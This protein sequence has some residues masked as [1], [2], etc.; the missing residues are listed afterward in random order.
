MSVIRI[1]KSWTTNI[2][3]VALALLGPATAWAQEATIVSPRRLATV[4]GNSAIEVDPG[5]PDGD[6]VKIVVVVDGVEIGVLDA[7]PW[8][9]D[10]RAGDGS[11]GHQISARVETRS[12][13]TLL[14]RT[15]TSALRI[16]ATEGVN[17]VNLYA[18]VRTRGGGYASRLSKQDFVVLEDGKRQTIERFSS[19]RKPLRV[20][21]VL[22][23]SKTMDGRKLERAKEAAREF[24]K[25][26]GPQD[27]GMVVT[28]DNDVRID[29]GLTHDTRA[30]EQAIM[31]AE[32]G[33]GTALYDA[34]YR[35]ARKLRGFD[36]RRVMVLLS[37]G[38]DEAVNGI[39]PGSLHTLDE[40]L[41]QALRAEV[42]IF[43]IG[44][45]R[46]LGE[47]WDFY[48]TRSLKSILQQLANDTGG[49]ALISSGPGE[50]RRAFKSVYEDLSNQYTLA[51]TPTNAEGNG[52]WRDVQVKL[53]DDD[54]EVI[55]RKGY[56]APTT[57]SSE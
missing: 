23:T 33:G 42:M 4:L 20:G 12:N 15:R 2:W 13:G 32:P 27:E 8:R 37:D 51:Y 52:A 31:Q 56:F 48:R 57:D 7:P 14:A 49:R 6:V 25:T 55:T 16:N 18:V 19:E 38:R 30:L 41:E 26:L 43:S 29:Q 28:F 1:G 40:S 5:V 50:L 44:L 54:Y 24:L 21:F 3:M 45:G 34:I 10:W 35:T 46:R 11:R 36:G 47:T 53:V 39:E 9:L 17:L 22:D